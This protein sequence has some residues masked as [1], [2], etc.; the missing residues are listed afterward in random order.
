M[1]TGKLSQIKVSYPTFDVNVGD[2]EKHLKS[3]VVGEPPHSHD[4]LTRRSTSSGTPTR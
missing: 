4:G 1:Q 3:L 2:F